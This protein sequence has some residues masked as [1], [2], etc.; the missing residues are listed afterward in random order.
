MCPIPQD[1]KAVLAMAVSK[2]FRCARQRK[3]LQ[4]HGVTRGDVQHG[5]A[6][7]YGDWRKEAVALT[8]EVWEDFAEEEL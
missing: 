1:F 6:C 7:F 3:V 8:R 2:S 5:V 4:Q